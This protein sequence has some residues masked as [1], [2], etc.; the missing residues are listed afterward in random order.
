MIAKKPEVGIGLIGS[1]FMGR[2]H[3]NAF[4]AVAGLFDLPATPH[5]AVL[6]DATDE[7]FRLFG[8]SDGDRDVDG[9]DYGRFALTFLKSVGTAGF[10]SALDFDGDGDVDGRDYGNFGRRFLKTLPPG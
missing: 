10:N 7:F 9:Q 4:T 1:G 2:C 8:D 3:A 5:C 6:A